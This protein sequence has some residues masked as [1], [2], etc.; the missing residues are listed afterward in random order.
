MTRPFKTLDDMGDIAGKRV[1]VRE[2]LNV[3]MADGQVT[4]DTRLRAAVQTV[5]ELADKGA[6]VIVLAHFGRPKGQRN[7]EMS[8]SLVTRPF[9]H[10]LGR[11]VRFIDTD[12][13][14]EAIAATRESRVER[15]R[16]TIR[17]NRAAST[18]PSPRRGRAG[19]PR[20][21]RRH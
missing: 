20:A 5:A 21:R 4:D 6:K 19:S 8:L 1:L 10:V 12:G 2:D 7:P 18:Q 3:P 9:S 11:E 13:A 16:E 14:A 17:Q 15:V